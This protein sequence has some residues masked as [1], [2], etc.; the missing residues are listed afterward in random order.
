MLDILSKKGQKTLEQER[1]AIEIWHS[2]VPDWVYNETP[3]DSPSP[4]DAII[5]NGGCCRAVVETKCRDMSEDMFS[6]TFDK[7][8]LVT[9]DK[10]LKAKDIADSLQI[11]F[12]G[13]LYLT[14]SN[15]LIWQKLWTPN[16][17]W[18][19]EIDVRK[20]KTQATVNG[21]EIYRDNAYIDMKD[22]TVWRM[23]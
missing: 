8:W 3:K 4:V 18:L 21:G 23:K 1:Q 20:T 14:K 22:A 12:L 15:C 19:I 6:N 2:H 7:K 13:F 5:T 16:K 9:F 17:G 10:I 11:P